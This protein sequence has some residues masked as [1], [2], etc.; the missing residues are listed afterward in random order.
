[1]KNKKNKTKSYRQSQ[2]MA[3]T[4]QPTTT[5]PR[6]L[7]LSLETEF[8]FEDLY[9]PLIDLL[10]SRA[11]LQRVTKPDAARR[12]LNA[13]TPDA[14][15]ITD[16]ALVDR[17]P[18]YAQIL[19][20]VV[21][22]VRAGGIA[23]FACV[24]SSFVSYIDLDAFFAR[25]FVLPWTTGSYQGAPFVLNRKVPLAAVPQNR[26]RL[27]ARY[28]TKAVFL[29]GVADEHALYRPDPEY[30]ADPT[31]AAVAF[32]PVGQGFVGYVG[33]VNKDLGSDAAV[34]IMCGF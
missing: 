4:A 28:H 30:V 23:V 22:Y 8:F 33:D 21:A 14:I 10:S 29:R 24:F 2:K 6:I 26:N 5:Q 34:L 17:E 27:Q 13:N 31:E 15:L 32:A 11:T 25:A 18:I 16:P 12:Y 1:L 19:A 3:T 9:A 20:Q 7:L